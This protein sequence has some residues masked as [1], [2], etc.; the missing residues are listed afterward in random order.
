MALALAVAGRLAPDVAP[1]SPASSRRTRL[2]SDRR[3]SSAWTN[4]WDPEP[5]QGTGAFGAMA[6]RTALVAWQVRSAPNPAAALHPVAEAVLPSRAI[7]D[8]A[9]LPVALVQDLRRRVGALWGSRPPPS[10]MG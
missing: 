3:G 4:G 8:P 2:A 7:L 6:S 1:R 5:R 10:E 9:P